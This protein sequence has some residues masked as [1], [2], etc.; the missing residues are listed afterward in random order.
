MVYTPEQVAELMQ[1][2]TS[3]VYK[4]KDTLGG[5]YPAGI[6]VLRFNKGVINGILEG[7]DPQRLGIQV[8]IS[9]PAVRGQGVQDQGRGQ[10]RQGKPSKNGKGRT[11]DRNRHNLFGGCK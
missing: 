3:V 10:G 6:K 2:S 4:H 1:V 5:F 7:Q 8:P 9:G 11:S